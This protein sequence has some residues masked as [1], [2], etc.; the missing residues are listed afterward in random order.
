MSGK[1]RGGGI[2]LLLNER[3]CNNVTVKEKMCTKDVELLSVSIRPF[4]LPRE[5]S[6]VFV[7]ALYIPPDANVQNATDHV[8]EVV[9]NLMNNKPDALHIILGDANHAVDA[10][11][12]KLP[13]YTQY[14]SCATRNET[15]LDPFYCNVKNSYRSVELPPLMNSDHKMIHMQPIY[16]SK[17]KQ[18]KPKTIMKTSL[19]SDSEEALNACFEST[20]WDLFIQ[21]CKVD[22]NALTDVVTSYILFCYNLHAAKKKVTLFGNNKP[23]V[24]TELRQALVMTHKS[25]G[26][27]DYAENHKKICKMIRQA[28]QAYTEKVEGLFASND[29]RDAWRGLKILTGMDKQRKIPAIITTPGSANRLNEFYSRFDVEDMS[30]VNNNIRVRLSETAIDESFELDIDLVKKSL[31]KVKVRKASGPDG[32]GGRII[33]ACQ[34]SLPSEEF[35]LTMISL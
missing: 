19:N 22:V 16:K 35:D 12:N 29:T 28:K 13:N 14:V 24:T 8:Q 23:W 34:H 26:S 7:T 25:Y 3:W 6:N 10:I 17:L 31:R 1:S 20:D 27:A 2:A 18:V 9:V 21:D 5:F 11:S 32:I 4:Y 15:L 33:K 30:E